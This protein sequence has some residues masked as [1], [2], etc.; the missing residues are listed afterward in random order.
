MD[1]SRNDISGY[2][3]IKKYKYMGYVSLNV[4]VDIDDILYSLNRFEKKALFNLLR[5]DLGIDDMID[6]VVVGTTTEQELF[7]ICNNIY[8]NRNSLTNEDKVLLVKLSKKGWYQK[9]V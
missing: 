7:N 2:K 8:E 1:I 4:D 3:I 9:V 5:E 6:E